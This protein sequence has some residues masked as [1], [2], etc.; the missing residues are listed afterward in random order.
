MKRILK[1]ALLLSLPLAAAGQTTQTQAGTLI[2]AGQPDQAALVRLNG[3]SY[4]DIESL[5]RITHGSVRFQGSQT[6]LSLPS[7]SSAPSASSAVGEGAA[8][9]R[10]ISER[11][12]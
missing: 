10:R 6:I 4:V 2:I 11:R 12:D 5:A 9:L 7:S 8:T 3:K 1:L